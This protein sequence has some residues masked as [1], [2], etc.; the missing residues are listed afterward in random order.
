M[1]EKPWLKHY[2]PGLPHTLRPYPEC[3]L[4][5]VMSDTVRQRPDHTA[6]IFKG[7]RV[8]YARA[9][10]VDER[11]RRRARGAGRQEGRPRG[12]AAAELAAEH[13][14]PVGRLEGGRDRRPHQ[15][16]LHA[17][18]AGACAERDR[19][20]DG[21]RPDPLLRQGQV[22]AGAHA[23]P[24]RDRDEHQRVPAGAPALAVYP[25]QGEKGGPPHPAAAGRPVV[26]RPDA[27]ACGGTP[28]G[29]AAGAR[30][31]GD[32]PVQRRHHRHAQGG[33]R[34][35]PRAVDVGDAAPCLRAH[36][37]GR[38][39]RYHHPGDAHVPRV[40]QH[41]AE[42]VARRALA[43]GGRP[44]PARHRRLDRHDHARCAP[45]CCM[46]CRRCSSRCSTTPR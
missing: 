21:R 9:G 10:A 27:P 14:R 18:R 45:P 43:D 3:T 35:A 28:A 7:A 19:R 13:H 16:A 30:R 29:R 39:G 2:E 11:V 40:R 25:G 17:A 15:L 33:A 5:D 23:G 44:Q 22:A 34:H 8:S 1:G 46:A 6:L 31:P 4:L 38:L 20:G 37:A 42:H 24:P 41:G 32:S 36:G 26:A 12:A